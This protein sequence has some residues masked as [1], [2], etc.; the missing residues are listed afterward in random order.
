MSKGMTADEFF[1]AMLQIAHNK[2]H[3]DHKCECAS[4]QEMIDF[5]FKKHL[6]K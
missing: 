3:P 6:E 5:H 4:I 1:C 2:E